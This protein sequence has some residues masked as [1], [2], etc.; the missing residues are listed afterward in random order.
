MS[1]IRMTSGRGGW[2]WV[3]LTRVLI[4]NI[5]LNRLNAH[6]YQR[7]L[8]IGVML[9]LIYALSAGNM[10]RACRILS[11]CMS[12]NIKCCRLGKVNLKTFSLY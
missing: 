11:F 3:W 1:Q 4:P 5:I 12:Y 10:E 6:K 7:A 9:Y 8:M 2:Q